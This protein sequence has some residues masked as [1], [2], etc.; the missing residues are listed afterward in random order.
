MRRIALAVL[1][2]LAAPAAFAAVSAADRSFLTHEAQ[3]GAYELAIAQLAT[4]KGTRD[5]IKA[6]AQRIVSDHEQANTALQQLA[7]SKGVSLPTGM[8]NDEQTRFAG[9]QN[10][11]GTTFDRAYVKEAVRI[12]AGD[13]RDFAKEA[14]TTHDA[15]IRAYV[16]RFAAM[17]A[18]HE[19]A[20]KQLQTS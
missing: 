12:N 7:Q 2:I 15:D 16:Q 14:K 18:E 5:D 4:Q 13:K 20:A 17:D 8:T 1:L 6:Y 9:L 3:G 19:Q 11:Q 10:L